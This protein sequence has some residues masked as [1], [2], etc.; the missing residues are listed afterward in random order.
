M[1]IDKNKYYI[2]RGDRSGVYF[3]KITSQTGYEVEMAE[4]RN[5]WYWE[6][7]HTILQLAKDGTAKPYAC[8]FTVTVDSLVLTDVVEII[9]CTE[10][11][12]QSIKS[13]PEWKHG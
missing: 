6:G 11:A 4:A 12:V 8:C 9:P 2:V 10:K 5:I 3:G 13:V 1:K 7:A